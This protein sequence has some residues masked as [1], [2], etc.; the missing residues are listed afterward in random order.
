MAG[1]SIPIQQQVVQE[2]YL[3]SSAIT[4]CL[5]KSITPHKTWVNALSTSFVSVTPAHVYKLALYASINFMHFQ[6]FSNRL[7]CAI[8]TRLMLNFPVDTEI[9]KFIYIH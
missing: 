5:K 4:Y 3:P 1:I 2:H 6:K 8:R 9:C 7:I